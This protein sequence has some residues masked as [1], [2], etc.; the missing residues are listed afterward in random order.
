MCNN[1]YKEKFSMFNE[2]KQQTRKSQKISR[3]VH[4]KLVLNTIEL[5]ENL[6][7]YETSRRV[8]GNICSLNEGMLRNLRNTWTI[9]G[10]NV[11]KSSKNVR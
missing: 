6:F 9:N 2:G 4:S 10:S 5:V 1:V 11:C 7:K 3:G 8:L